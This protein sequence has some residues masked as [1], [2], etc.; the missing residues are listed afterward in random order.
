MR[1]YG[2]TRIPLVE[3]SCY[4]PNMRK[5]ELWYSQLVDRA[6]ARSI[7]VCYT[8]RHHIKP[9][10]LGGRDEPRNIVR[11]T[12]REHFIAHWLLTKFTVGGDL[13]K[14]QRAF[15][16][17]TLPTSGRPIVSS[18][19]FEAAK[20]AVRDLELDPVA[21][22]LWR[23]RQRQKQLQR[24]EQSQAKFKRRQSEKQD[25]ARLDAERL[26]AAPHLDRDQL[27]RL[28]MSLEIAAAPP[29]ERKRRGKPNRPAPLHQRL[30]P[31][32]AVAKPRKPRHRNR[33]KHRDTQRAV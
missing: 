25:R 28:A 9:R 27:F 24:A 17:M 15:F 10:S 16:A 1:S 20:R 30:T 8:E 18:W 21:E 33:R 12:Y 14:M 13:R 3:K 26:L 7:P 5:Y 22:E 31:V 6:Q 23:D 29:T 2:P 32:E 11:L 19:R 4:R